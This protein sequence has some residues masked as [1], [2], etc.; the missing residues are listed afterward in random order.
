[1]NEN[2]LV[3]QIQKF[4]VNDGPGFRTNVFLK[5]CP[6]KCRWCHN[7][8][9][10]SAKPELFWKQ[11]LCIQCGECVDACPN[12]AINLPIHP[13]EAAR[14]D[15]IYQKIIRDRCDKCMLCVEACHYGALEITGEPMTI[16]EIL[17]EVEQD[18]PFYARSGGGMTLSGGE[19][20]SH[21]EFTGKLLDE[22]L[23]RGLHICLD[24]CGFCKWEILESLSKKA[25]IILYDLK[26]LDP[27]KHSM[28]TGVDNKL[29]L[30]NLTKLVRSGA[31]IWVRIVVIPGFSDT[32][33]YH[34]HVA[35][36]L[37]GL[38]GKLGRIDLLP[39]HNW[40]EDKYKWLDREW[41]MSEYQALDPAVL[42]PLE[43]L[44]KEKGLN[45]TIGGSGFENPVA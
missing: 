27:E 44:Y 31:D 11:R 24:T 14:E 2:V 6:L 29:I 9:T 17:T 25:H 15:F 5:G 22:A 3:T 43:E 26:H 4:A 12:D 40:C 45:V 38:P 13:E 20:T 35:E 10:Q 30:E 21:L 42:I 39:Y 33:D 16:D 36:F 41:L 37:S 18:A 34:R 28:M 1:M 23:K 7:P 19:P 8:E 32:L